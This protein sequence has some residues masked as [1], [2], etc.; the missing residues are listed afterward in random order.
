MKL[1]AKSYPQLD[2]ELASIYLQI[3]GLSSK[4]SAKHFGKTISPATLPEGSW[5]F[6]G[7]AF[8]VHR[9]GTQMAF[10]KGYNDVVWSSEIYTHDNRY[11]RYQSNGSVHVMPYGKLKQHGYQEN[12]W[13]W[14]RNPGATELKSI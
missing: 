13:D 4:D 9:H 7:G 8:A 5:S 1:L 11:G 12:G 10:M 2:E 14:A 6:N 3:R